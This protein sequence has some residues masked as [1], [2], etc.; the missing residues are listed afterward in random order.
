MDKGKFNVIQD[1][2]DVSADW[3]GAME[4]E[5]VKLFPGVAFKKGM[6]RTHWWLSE[7]Y[8][9]EMRHEIDQITFRKEFFYNLLPKPGAIEAIEWY[10]AQGFAVTICTSPL[11]TQH[12][13]SVADCIEQKL[14]WIKKYTGTLC[15]LFTP[16]S[17]IQIAFAWDKT[18]IKGNVL[19]DDRPEVTG[20]QIPDWHHL[21]FDNGHA[22]AK[23]SMKEKINWNNY[24]ELITE[25]YKRWKHGKK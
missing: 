4:G 10:L 23:S 8:P 3:D 1:L 18:Q 14:R 25:H 17:P 21:L 12:V 20:S 22:Y 2:D 6:D 16:D 19:I 15:T 9:I 7:N 11:W 24:R 5:F 13:P